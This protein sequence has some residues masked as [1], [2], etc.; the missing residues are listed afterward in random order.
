VP[1]LRGN[2]CL[3]PVL[4]V[5]GSRR[6][7]A[8]ELQ[9]GGRRRRVLRRLVRLRPLVSEQHGEQLTQAE[10]EQLE[11]ELAE[12]AGPRRQAIVEAIAVARA[13]GDLSENFEY[14]AAKNEQGLLERRITILQS[15]L[16]NA[17]VIDEEAAAAS[18]VVT[19][20]SHVELKR[21]DGEQMNV[22][23]SSVGGVSPESP[24]GRAVLGKKVG[25]EIVVEAPRG[26]WRAT[27]LSI[28]R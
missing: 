14:H 24:V 5:C 21:E 2:G 3:A 28:G 19:V 15:R 9:A 12:L 16:H 10:R 7:E 25:D 20:G 11:A 8:A 6:R 27:V 22:E 17:E 1:R 18:G 26:T 4:D 23:I 13:H